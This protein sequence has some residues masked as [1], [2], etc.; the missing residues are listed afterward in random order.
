VELDGG[1]WMSEIKWEIRHVELG[2]PREERDAGLA[3]AK[4][5]APIQ[6][7]FSIPDSETNE[8]P[9]LVTCMFSLSPSNAPTAVQQP[10]DFPTM[11]PSD[12]PTVSIQSEAPTKQVKGSEEKSPMPSDRPSLVPSASDVDNNE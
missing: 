11:V 6:C 7:Q 9:C 3:A 1:A 10:S 12:L 2:I 4:G 5:L 8:L